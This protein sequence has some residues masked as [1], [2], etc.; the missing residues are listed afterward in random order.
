MGE[1]KLRVK[2][3][4][5]PVVLMFIPLILIFSCGRQKAE[6]KGTIEVVDGVTVVKNTKEP[7]YNREIFHFEEELC[8]GEAEGDEKYMF[9]QI[10]SICVDDEGRIFVADWKESHI[11]VFDKDGRYLMTIGRKGQ[12]PGEFESIHAIQIT[13]QTDY[14]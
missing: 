9:T 11:K 14:D 7:M 5:I 10:A 1:D 12:G 3:E 8:I 13:N 2:T 6:W 4:W